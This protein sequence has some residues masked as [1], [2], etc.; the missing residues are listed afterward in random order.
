MYIDRFAQKFQESGLRL[1]ETKVSGGDWI[2]NDDKRFAL[3][4]LGGKF[5]FR[6][7]VH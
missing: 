5:E 4:L 6:S 2:F 1:R 7:K 3:L